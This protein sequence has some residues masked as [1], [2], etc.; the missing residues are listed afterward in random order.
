M[1]ILNVL[2]NYHFEENVEQID[3][4]KTC[5]AHNDFCLWNMLSVNGHICLVDWEMA[6]EF[7]IG[8]DLFT[9]IFQTTF[10]IQN[11]V[12]TNIVLKNN[13]QL[14]KK[15]FGDIDYIPYLKHF[16]D[17]KINFFSSGQNPYGLKRYMEL[18]AI[19]EDL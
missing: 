14:I 9:Y 7:P 12:P 17:Y 4:L 6:G 19:V 11:A 15:Y 10:F 3:G 13:L 8:H 1:T 2:Q 18:K 5:F 16:V